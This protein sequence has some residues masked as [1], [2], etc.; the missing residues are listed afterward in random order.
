[1]LG[2]LFFVICFCAWLGRYLAKR[3]RMYGDYRKQG[4]DRYG[5]WQDGYR[6]WH[7]GRRE[8]VKFRIGG[9]DVLAM[10][11]LRSIDKYGDFWKW[12]FVVRDLTLE[13]QIR[14]EQDEIAVFRKDMELRKKAIEEGKDFYEV[15]RQCGYDSWMINGK[16]VNGKD[17]KQTLHY[18][19]R[20]VDNNRLYFVYEKKIYDM[21][22]LL[23][24][25]YIV[26]YLKN[27][28][29]KK[30]NKYK[31]EW[32][33]TFIRTDSEIV[34]EGRGDVRDTWGF[35]DNGITNKYSLHDN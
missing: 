26:Y 24:Y 13:E 16:D 23:G 32:D 12:N 3:E 18:L 15:N 17:M 27:E 29:L 14:R 25:K 35:S 5:C 33:R 11:E 6:H 9:H 4:T 21:W 22:K 30:A 20:R 1:M 10:P 2:M 31:D 19:Y 28:F 7:Y 34:K 8:I